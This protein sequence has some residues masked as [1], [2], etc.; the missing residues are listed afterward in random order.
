MKSSKRTFAALKPEFEA[1]AKMFKEQDVDV[2]MTYHLAYSPSLESIDAI[3]SVGVPVV[4]C[5]TTITY[6]MSV[7]MDPC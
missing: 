2:L 4:V 6:D 3:V 7:R 1:A 5:D